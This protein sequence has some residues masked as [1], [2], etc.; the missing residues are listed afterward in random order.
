MTT[1]HKGG[2]DKW[3]EMSSWIDVVEICRLSSR[4]MAIDAYGELLVTT[5][6]QPDE[7]SNIYYDE[8]EK[9]SSWKGLIAYDG[10]MED[11]A[12]GL[13]YDGSLL[14]AKW[15][16]EN[17]HE[18][19]DLGG[20]DI[21]NCK[22]VVYCIT[23]YGRTV[24]VKRDG[25]VLAVGG[26]DNHGDNNVG[27][28]N[29]FDDIIEAEIVRAINPIKEKYSSLKQRVL[30]EMNQCMS[31]NSQRRKELE[32][33]KRNLETR[34]SGLGLFKRKGK[35]SIV[36]QIADIDSQ[37]ERLETDQVIRDRYQP[38]LTEINN[39]EEADIR[40]VSEEIRSKYSI[41]T[42]DEFQA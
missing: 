2:D 19:Y 12:I 41:V 3:S 27:S 10:W 31:A 5:K 18:H 29:L 23:N 21:G 14:S 42:I 4:M 33:N 1:T 7:E 30:S 9:I 26:I 38:R 24:W 32:E 17:G 39:Q 40:S 8:W 36:S 13:K 25:S 22:N 37:L 28:F 16:A 11:Y 34:R 35:V 20:A 15:F 6:F